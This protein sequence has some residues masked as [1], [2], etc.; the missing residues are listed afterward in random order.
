MTDKPNSY[1]II[2]AILLA[3][4]VSSLILSNFYDWNIT[5]NIFIEVSMMSILILL[6]L[7]VGK[8]LKEE[9]IE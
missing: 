3:I 5:R 2:S 6:G 4:A 9:K 7:R 8:L 1:D